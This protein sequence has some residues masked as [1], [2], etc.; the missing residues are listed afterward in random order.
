MDL[1]EFIQQALVQV[2]EGLTS[3]LKR[4]SK[5]WRNAE[6]LLVRQA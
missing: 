5:I 2:A 1:K 4:Q 3:A 6:P